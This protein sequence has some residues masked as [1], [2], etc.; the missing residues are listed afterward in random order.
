M[1]ISEILKKKRKERNYTQEEVAKKLFVSQKSISNWERNKTYPDIDSLIRLANLYDLS[2]DSILLEGSAIVEDI[3]EQ[4]EIRKL[5]IVSIFP[6]LVNLVLLFLLVGQ[7]WLGQLTDKIS[8]LLILSLIMNFIS[9]FFIK[10]KQIKL[11]K[12][13]AYQPSRNKQ[14]LVIVLILFITV[15]ACLFIL[16]IPDII[17]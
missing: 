6:L 5:R 15:S 16:K 9:L 4:A 1:E 13:H 7:K 14:I 11:Q 3:K 12:N 10:N 2:L 8:Y 17:G